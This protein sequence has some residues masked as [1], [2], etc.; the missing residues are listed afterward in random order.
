M[1]SSAAMMLASMFVIAETPRDSIAL[2]VLCFR[3]SSDTEDQYLLNPSLL[4]LTTSGSRLRSDILWIA[5]AVR[6]RLCSWDKDAQYRLARSLR[7]P[8]S[9][10]ACSLA[11]IERLAFVSSVSC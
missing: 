4:A 5:N 2:A 6:S 1:R 10:V 11:L 3:T 8:D 7:S 9:L